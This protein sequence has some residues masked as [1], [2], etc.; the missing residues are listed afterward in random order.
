MFVWDLLPS[1]MF[2]TSKP[3]KR[4]QVLKYLQIN[5]IKETQNA[6]KETFDAL[7]LIPLTFSNEV[8]AF[9]KYVTHLKYNFSPV[10]VSTNG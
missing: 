5:A 6:I 4:L 9:K 1:Q 10:S 7:P 8:L 3:S 2:V